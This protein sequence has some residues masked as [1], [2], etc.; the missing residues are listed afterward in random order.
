MVP[1]FGRPCSDINLA[2][3]IIYDH[4]PFDLWFDFFVWR[5]VPFLRFGIDVGVQ[6]GAVIITAGYVQ[7]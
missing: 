7:F 5:E 6:T 2:A 3:V 1:K 4:K